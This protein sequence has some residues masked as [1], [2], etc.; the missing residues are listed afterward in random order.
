MGLYDMPFA[1]P[2]MRI[3]NGEAEAHTR[4][5]WFRSVLEH[6]A[7]LRRAVLRRR[8]WRMPPGGT[9]RTTCWS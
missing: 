8:R 4:I 9:R 1:I 5:G 7:C 3:E 6:P 2:N